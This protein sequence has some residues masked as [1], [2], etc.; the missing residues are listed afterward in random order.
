MNVVL[1]TLAVLGFASVL[2]ALYVFAMATFFASKEG[3]QQLTT[4]KVSTSSGRYQV[5]SSQ[6]R[7]QDREVIFPL[8]LDGVIIEKDR[9]RIPERRQAAL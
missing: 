4:G 6:D 8:L 2:L 3:G 9:R 5:R 7:R 1:I